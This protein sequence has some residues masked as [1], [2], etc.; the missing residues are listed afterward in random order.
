M[1]SFYEDILGLKRIPNS[2]NTKDFVSLDAGGIQLC[3]HK[4]PQR[5][6]KNIEITD[7]PAPL[8]EVL[9]DDAQEPARGGVPVL[10][11]ASPPGLLPL[12][13]DGDAAVG[14]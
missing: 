10:E 3:L 13:P 12:A 4:I 2:E 14:G 11:G 6:A 7:P 5:Y 9:A 8:S 1:Q